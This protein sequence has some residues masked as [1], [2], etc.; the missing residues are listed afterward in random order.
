MNK[1]ARSGVVGYADIAEKLNAEIRAGKYSVRRS[2]PSLTKIMQR[3]DVTRVTAMRKL[4]SLLNRIARDPGFTP[5]P[6]PKSTKQNANVGRK[7]KAA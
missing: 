3:F 1:S 4:L 6:E 2:F 7:R 5:T